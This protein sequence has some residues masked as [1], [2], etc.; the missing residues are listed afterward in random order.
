[1]AYRQGVSG[2]AACLPPSP[3]PPE[4]DRPGPAGPA[5]ARPPRATASPVLP[6]PSW[7]CLP[8]RTLPPPR[9]PSRAGPTPLPPS[10]AEKNAIAGRIHARG[11]CARSRREPVQRRSGAIAAPQGPAADRRRHH[12]ALR[13]VHGT[14]RGA[15]CGAQRHRALHRRRPGAVAPDRPRTMPPA[16]TPRRTV[17]YRFAVHSFPASCC[18]TSPLMSRTSAPGRPSPTEVDVARTRTVLAPRPVAPDTLEADAFVLCRAEPRY[19]AVDALH[20]RPPGRERRGNQPHGFCELPASRR[21]PGVADRTGPT[22]K[23]PETNDR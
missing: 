4:N 3:P 10:G 2:I 20:R 9:P 1:M 21:G 5:L 12:R 7:S 14:R 22:D 11:A 16:P 6:V 17:V 13:R 15:R 19:S 18:P 23:P 8:R